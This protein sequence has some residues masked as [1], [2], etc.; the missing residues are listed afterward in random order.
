VGALLL[1]PGGA[2][3][4]L[5][6]PKADRLGQGTPVEPERRN[7]KLRQGELLALYTPGCG[8][9]RDADGQELG[10]DRF[11]QALGGAFGPP[12]GTVLEDVQQDLGGFFKGGRQPDDITVLLL[13]RP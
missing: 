10:Q 13:Y 12:P 6:D 3:R 11:T 5:T 8:T 7:D 2:H 1:G 4:T 9:I